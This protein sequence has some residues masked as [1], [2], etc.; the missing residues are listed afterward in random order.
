MIAPHYIFDQKL[1]DDWCWQ[2]L[3]LAL[4]FLLVSIGWR[5]LR[6]PP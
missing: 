2:T 4:A 5:M 6:K 1:F 3:K